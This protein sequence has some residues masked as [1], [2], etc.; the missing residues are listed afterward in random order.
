MDDPCEEGN[1]PYADSQIKK[2]LP[3]LI[4]MCSTLKCVTAA[5]FTSFL[6]LLIHS[7]RSP[8][9]FT[10]S[11]HRPSSVSPLVLQPGALSMCMRHP[12]SIPQ[13]LKIRLLATL[14]NL[15]APKSTR[16]EQSSAQMDPRKNPKSS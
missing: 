4:F 14:Q 9:H 12:S 3:Q 5:E 7:F 10:Y 15:Q 11:S 8:F 16:P 2:N 1:G 6:P 13:I